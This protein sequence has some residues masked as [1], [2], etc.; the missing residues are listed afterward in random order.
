MTDANP[1]SPDLLVP[2]R[3]F[4]KHAGLAAAGAVAVGH[5][6]DGT[7]K[8]LDHRQAGR[9]GVGGDHA[10]AAAARLDFGVL[11]DG[12]PAPFAANLESL[13]IDD[14]VID[15]RE[16]TTGLDVEY[17]TYGPGDAHFGKVTVRCR[18]DKHRRDDTSLGQW[19]RDCA[20]GR[21]LRKSIS[22]IC[23]KR[24]GS[25]ART[26]NLVDCFPTAYAP[27]EIG[28]G[29]RFVVERLVLRIGRVEM[30]AH[31]D[32]PKAP[33]PR[34]EIVVGDPAGAGVP[35]AA[36]PEADRGW[37]SL[38][39]GAVVL[40]DPDPV[41]GCAARTTTPGHK[42]IDTLTLRGPLT[43]GRKEMCAWFVDTVGGGSARR[44][45]TV[46]EAAKDR[47]IRTFTYH[48]C[49]PTR[50]VFPTFAAG[51]SGNLYE[52]VAIKPIRLELA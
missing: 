44:S 23:L 42:Y 46:R 38:S 5:A 39:G 21:N 45:V 52:E 35:G 27:G 32:A 8:A 3:A 19:W 6:G 50:Y 37:E 43:S 9:F 51:G 49:F 7:V 17:R 12:A 40:A 26:F 20:S 36:A 31:G 28:A 2:R 29:D 11:V 30:L 15:A 16:T 10:G 48:D 41:L 33:D 25:P 34:F 18:L 24:D 4:L 14:L 1:P 13:A 47:P 22:V